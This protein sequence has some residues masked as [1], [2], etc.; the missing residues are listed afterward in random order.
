[1]KRDVLVIAHQYLPSDP[2]VGKSITALN[3]VG[4]RVDVLCLREPGQ[5]F[6]GSMGAA[7]LYRL[8]VRRHRG[9]GLPMY[10]FEYAAFFTM[11]FFAAA[12]LQLHRR[13]RTVVT[14]TLPDPLV[15][16]ALVPKLAGAR[17]VMD[18]HEFTPE[19]YET[20]YR[21]GREHWLIRA[22]LTLERWSCRFADSVVT[23]HDP[24][25]DILARTGVTRDRIAVVMNTADLSASPDPNRAGRPFTL[26]YHG[27]LV[28]QYDLETVLEALA[29]LRTQGVDDVRLRIIGEGPGLEGVRSRMEA[30]GLQ[31]AVSLEPPVPLPRIPAILAECDAGVVPMHD[32]RYAH[33]ALPMKALEC[34]AGGLPVITNPTD[35]LRHYFDDRSVSWVP[36][37]DAVAMA[38]AIR[39]LRDDDAL[40]RELVAQAHERVRP[41]R[42]SVMAERFVE[43][44]GFGRA[45][46]RR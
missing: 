22:M 1:M 38:V 6:R 19:L 36:F 29:R 21:L 32:I 12:V 34:M 43:A 3:D 10:V 8:P 42:W 15:F 14:H 45:G 24:G 28:N 18:M 5:P 46:A 27:T 16:A 30:L 17:V 37:G 35:A 31:E 41:I 4:A 2:R 20:R 26:V 40:R 33:V 25:V 44:C 7:R 39:R 11:A 23:V 9:A 13:Y